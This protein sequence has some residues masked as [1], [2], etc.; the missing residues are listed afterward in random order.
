MHRKTNAD[1]ISYTF[2]KKS[3]TLK[4]KKKKSWIYSMKLSVI[5]L[6]LRLLSNYNK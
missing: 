3:N 1:V 5:G 2:Q 6:Q 4:K